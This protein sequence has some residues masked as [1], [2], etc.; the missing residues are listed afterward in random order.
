MP[1]TLVGSSRELKNRR[2]LPPIDLLDL[3]GEC[4]GPGAAAAMD[5]PRSPR[6]SS[7]PPRQATNRSNVATTQSPRS[8]D[9]G[10]SYAEDMHPFMALLNGRQYPYIG[11]QESSSCTQQSTGRAALSVSGAAPTAAV[12]DI[13]AVAEGA[14][15]SALGDENQA[16]TLPPTPHPSA[17]KAEN[18]AET[19]AP[20][21]SSDKTNAPKH[22]VGDEGRQRLGMEPSEADR[23]CDGDFLQGANLQAARPPAQP[24]PT[25][26]PHY[27]RPTSASKGVFNRRRRPRR[28]R[29][30]RLDI[31]TSSASGDAVDSLLR[32]CPA[33]E[34]RM[35]DLRRD[36][37]AAARFLR[38]AQVAAWQ[39]ARAKPGVLVSRNRAVCVLEGVELSSL[40]RQEA[41]VR[42][43]HRRKANRERKRRMEVRRLAEAEAVRVKHEGP[44]LAELQAQEQALQLERRQRFFMTVVIMINTT[45][46]LRNQWKERMWKLAKFAEALVDV[47]AEESSPDIFEVS[48]KR[49]QRLVRHRQGHG[50][51]C[52]WSGGGGGV[53][54]GGREKNLIRRLRQ[55]IPIAHA[56]WKGR[57][58]EGGAVIHDFLKD[59]RLTQNI[60]A[61]Y[62][63]R[64]KVI[65][66]QIYVKG[67]RVI[68]RDRLKLLGLFFARC[69]AKLRERL[70]ERVRQQVLEEA[71]ADLEVHRQLMRPSASA[72]ATTVDKLVGTA[73]VS[74][75]PAGI[76]CARGG[77]DG[78]WRSQQRCDN[79]SRR[80][81]GSRDND[82]VSKLMEAVAALRLK[83][84]LEELETRSAHPD[85]KRHLLQGL[86]E[87]VRTAHQG[88]IKLPQ[89][90]CDGSTYE[91]GNAGFPPVGAR[92][93]FRP[94][95]PFTVDD[96]RELLKHP[97]PPV[98]VC[99]THACHLSRRTLR[100]AA[101]AEYSPQIPAA[102]PRSA[103]NGRVAGGGTG[104]GSPILGVRARRMS[105]MLV[106]KGVPEAMMCQLV[107][108]AWGQSPIS[109][110]G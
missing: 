7:F 87:E 76:A 82:D 75:T 60:K 84:A 106:L 30:P 25:R 71:A 94:D 77:G 55:W 20:T 28:T 50:S 38:K 52:T 33:L 65:R 105:P 24:R 101:T 85:V 92:A 31:P 14:M 91:D 46:L 104:A 21:A 80:I 6:D 43:Q 29:G 2:L 13:T 51:C 23:N 44:S 56:R 62:R 93:G 10:D 32:L 36:N 63:F 100:T 66:C 3:L 49:I 16:D 53:T 34:A 4:N 61:I 102:P 17:A 37:T 108:T 98:G 97:L 79:G 74:P 109:S 8:L 90:G 86:L 48:V 89:K 35:M 41:A 95:T 70:A 57:R 96:A 88:R 27:A 54:I 40:R 42:S 58:H 73:S 69:E 107:L 11:G 9:T 68:T 15:S 1:I 78:R 99:C 110:S 72:A 26:P 59:A 39:K 67:V 45:V 19:S 103:I 22:T 5:E 64:R 12:P 47:R 81:G 18:L 83:S